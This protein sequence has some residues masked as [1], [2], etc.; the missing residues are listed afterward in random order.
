MLIRFFLDVS[1]GD[2]D[3]GFPVINGVLGLDAGPNCLI[4]LAYVGR[5]AE[6]I[7]HATEMHRSRLAIVGEQGN[8]SKIR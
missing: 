3:D 4:A 5:I 8:A 6:S 7:D 2:L 1:L